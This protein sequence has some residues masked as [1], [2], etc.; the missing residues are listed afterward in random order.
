M[1]NYLNHKVC[2]WKK[3]RSIIST[4][5]TSVPW[6]IPSMWEPHIP[7][8]E[9]AKVEECIDANDTRA[10]LW[11]L[12]NLKKRTWNLLTW[13]IKTHRRPSD[14]HQI[15]EGTEGESRAH[16]LENLCRKFHM[17]VACRQQENTYGNWKC[18][19]CDQPEKFG[20][21]AIPDT[22]SNPH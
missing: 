14:R 8:P 19:F 10:V 4:Y 9:K 22:F 13:H 5:I 21:T 6:I 3:I 1:K 16:I 11:I 20:L 18:Y 2:L 7:E 17:P 15:L 12:R